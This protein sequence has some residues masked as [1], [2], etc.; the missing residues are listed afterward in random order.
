ME[1]KGKPETWA[2]NI[3]PTASPDGGPLK[4]VQINLLVPQIKDKIPPVTVKD[5]AK[6]IS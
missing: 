5:K 4:D 2:T 3:L 1:Q 6:G